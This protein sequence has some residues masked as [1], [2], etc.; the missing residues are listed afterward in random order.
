CR[1]SPSV[2]A[3]RRHRRHR[4][5]ALR[6]RPRGGRT[7]RRAVRARGPRA[8]RPHRCSRGRSG[9]DP[10][11][12]R[13]PQPGLRDAG[14]LARRAPGRARPAR[15]RPAD[16]GRVA[17]LAPRREGGGARG[18][19][20]RARAFPRTRR[21]R[22]GGG[23]RGGHLMEAGATRIARAR[24][25]A[26]SADTF[27]RLSYLALAALFLIVVTG[28]T[29]RL[30]DSGLGCENWP[31]CGNTFLP[32]QGSHAFIEFGNRVAGVLVG[33]TTL[34]AAIAGWRVA[35]APRRLVWAA[36]A[37]PLLVLA[38]GILGGITVLVHLH[39]LIVM[40]HF[41]LSL[42]AVAVAVV[43][44]LGATELARGRRIAVRPA[45]L[46]WLGLLLLPP[47][48]VLV[49]TGTLVT[50]AGPHSGGADVKRF[51]NLVDAL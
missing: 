36:V 29:V 8:P 49:V 19:V 16:S 51:G 11:R 6:A 30:T 15:L 47:T 2:R 39:P 13:R 1:G 42:L 5:R 32:Q 4:F 23:G 41:L 25:P 20:P 27:R 7:Q 45:E 28:A 22:R 10:D 40:G 34:A 38:Q 21:P 33:L 37:L 44:A 43:V 9:R 50:A 14:P 24:L 3:E 18:D 12:R 48:L 17:R 26:V 35:L 31:R 46:G